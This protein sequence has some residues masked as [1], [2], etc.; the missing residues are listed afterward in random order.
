MEGNQGRDGFEGGLRVTDAAT[1]DVARDV[2][3]GENIK[4]VDYLSQSLSHVQPAIERRFAQP[5]GAEL[6]RHRRRGA[7][8]AWSSS[9]TRG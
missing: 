5:P 1:M 3:I 8:S 9:G 2:F 4:L 7:G 6:D